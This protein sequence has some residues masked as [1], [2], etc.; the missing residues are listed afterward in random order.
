MFANFEC[1]RRLKQVNWLIL[2]RNFLLS[3]FFQSRPV[4]SFLSSS[5]FLWF[6]FA[7]LFFYPL[8]FQ[9]NLSIFATSLT[10][11]QPRWF[12]FWALLK[13]LVVIRCKISRML[14]LRVGLAYYKS[15]SIKEWF[16]LL[17]DNRQLAHD[18]L[19]LMEM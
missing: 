13:S 12:V 15:T 2:F 4:A 3:L 7:P 5:F 16:A 14:D 10:A 19:H 9:R 8:S 11:P 6:S 18:M 1:S 17:T